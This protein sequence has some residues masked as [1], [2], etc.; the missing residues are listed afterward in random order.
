VP[1][2]ASA[3]TIAEPALDELLLMGGAQSKPRDRCA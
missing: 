1:C 2:L 3:G